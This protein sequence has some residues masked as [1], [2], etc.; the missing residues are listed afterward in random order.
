MSNLSDIP[1]LK[2]LPVAG[3]QPQSNK[4]VELVN[5]NKHAEERLLRLLDEL[6]RNYAVDKHW[7][8]MARAHFEQGFMCLNRSIFQPKRIALPEDDDGA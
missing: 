2:G 8:D 1:D 7:M 4:A 3:Y 5:A 6:D